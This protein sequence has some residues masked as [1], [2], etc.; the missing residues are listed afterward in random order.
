L[1]DDKHDPE[2]YDRR[3]AIS[4]IIG[5]LGGVLVIVLMIGVMLY[6]THDATPD[7]SAARQAKL[8]ELRAAELKAQSEFSWI[9]KN[10]GTVRLPIDVAMDKVLAEG[11]KLPA[12][13][14]AKK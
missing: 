7:D 4:T 13:A 3:R 6:A 9:D 11:F 10:K 14:P 8:T 1:S 12:T 2:A 5:T